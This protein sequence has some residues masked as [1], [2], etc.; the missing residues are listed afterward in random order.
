MTKWTF[1]R[2]WHLAGILSD[3]E[4]TKEQDLRYMKYV[5]DS[6]KPFQKAQEAAIAK[7]KLTETSRSKPNMT[8]EE[9]IKIMNK[10]TS[11]PSDWSGKWL[12][13]FEALGMIKLEPIQDDKSKAITYLRSIGYEGYNVCRDL[14]AAGFKI[15]R[16][17]QED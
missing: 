12:D 2:N 1:D 13:A 14:T 16:A 7:N 3:P 15:V 4:Y 11:G 8:R 5:A 10:V 6:L 17:R 9:A